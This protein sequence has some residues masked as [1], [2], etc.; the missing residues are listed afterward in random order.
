M[1]MYRK[2]LYFIVLLLFLLLFACDD[3]GNGS[4]NSPAIIGSW[5]KTG[6]YILTFY[7]SGAVTS[8][9][10]GTGTYGNGTIN[11]AV[12]LGNSGTGSYNLSGTK[13]IISGFVR[14]GATN[15]NQLNGEW[16][17]ME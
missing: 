15:F 14:V 5:T 11:L 8:N 13:L 12:P 4:S 2:G 7:N 1:K 3:S 17:K 10:M 9:N 6:G 16:L